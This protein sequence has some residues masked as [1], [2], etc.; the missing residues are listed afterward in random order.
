MNLHIEIK[1]EGSKPESGDHQKQ[2]HGHPNSS[3]LQ[4]Y[5]RHHFD[6]GTAHIGGLKQHLREPLIPL[7]AVSSQ[8]S[9]TDQYLHT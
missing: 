4:I 3:D 1:H 6:S 5:S 8:Y 7:H 9:L 2:L